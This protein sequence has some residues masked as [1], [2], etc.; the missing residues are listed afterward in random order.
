MNFLE[1]KIGWKTVDL[2]LL[3]D[4]TLYPTYLKEMILL[5]NTELSCDISL[6]QIKYIC[7]IAAICK[8]SVVILCVI[9]VSSEEV[10]PIVECP[11]CLQPCS[12]AVQLP[13]SHVFCFLC[14]KGVAGRNRRCALCRADIPPDFLRR[15][16]LIGKDAV[17]LSASASADR[18]QL[19]GG[20]LLHENGPVIL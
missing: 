5:H 19:N 12:Y 16:V 2:I 20:R 7:S 15:P 9:S 11:V 4:S 18:Q 14:L 17:D 1:D 13:C 3:V 10:A 8:V 6:I